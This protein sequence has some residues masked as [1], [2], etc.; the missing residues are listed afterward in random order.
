MGV[1]EE[2]REA[3]PGIDSNQIRP[4]G[5]VCVKSQGVVAA[6]LEMEGFAAAKSARR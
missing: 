5:E 4:K 3:R 1:I 2:L 6:G